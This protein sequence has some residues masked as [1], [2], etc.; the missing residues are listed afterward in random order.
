MPENSSPTELEGQILKVK[1][2]D[3][4]TG[5]AVLSMEIDG[6]RNTVTAVG[7]IVSPTP[8]ERLS[9]RGEWTKH[10]K[11]GAQFKVETFAVKNPVSAKGIENFLGSGL[12]KGI[13]PKMAS[14]IV[15][16]FGT[17]SL[18]IIE[19][20]PE[21]LNKIEGVGPKRIKMIKEAWDEQKHIRDLMIFLQA[22]GVG[23]GTAVRIF[24]KY[25]Q[26]SISVLKKNPYALASEVFGIGFRTA[27]D[28]AEKLGFE[29]NSPVRIKAGI[30]FVL[31]RLSDEGHTYYPE[32]MLNQKS[33]EILGVPADLIENSLKKL[34]MTGEVIIDETFSDIDDT[35]SAVYLKRFHN[36]EKNIA[37]HL[38]RIFS[39]R[40]ALGEINTEKAGKWVQSKSNIELAQRQISAVETAVKSKL[41][42]ITG[43][44]GTGKTT[45]INAIIKIFNELNAKIL[46][47]APTGRAANRMSEAAS[48]PAK[49]IHRALEYAPNQG[50]F[51]RNREN[52][53][54]I[55]VLILDEASMIDT[56][57]M[58]C[59]LEA[60]PDRAAV[61]M[62]GDIC[63]LPSVGAGNVLGDIIASG[64]IPC[65]ELNEIFRQAE[66][67]CIILNAHR[68]NKGLLPE[69][70]NGNKD[71]DFFF[72]EQDNPERVLNIIIE[73]VTKRIPGKFG[74]D[75]LMDIQVIS[76]MHKGTT[77][78]ASL[79][80]ALQEAVNPGESKLVKGYRSFR[81]NDK[82]M[83]TKNNYDKDVYNGDTGKITYIDPNSQTVKILFDQK[84]VTY[85]YSEMDEL[86]L[87]YAISVHKSQ[88]S[89]YPA[90]ILPLLTEHY[91]LLQRNLIY[92]AITRGKKLVVV[93][94]SKKAL[95]MGVKND[96][97]I[98]RYTHLSERIKK[99]SFAF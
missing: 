84:E 72:I 38:K 88:G 83:Q 67:S 76:P 93:T 35:S 73:L 61:I 97:I 46:L 87:A 7:N 86:T 44:P 49:T 85:E 48:S 54:D 80:N 28:I 37:E 60:V 8:G 11:F 74:F 52:P 26:G 69:F 90:V 96:R 98:K 47:A 92:T 55:D 65:I 18:E 36:A 20:S 71:T 68:V 58:S 63:Q 13:G 31:N 94:G 32:K 9:I 57:L 30:V 56:R 25:G 19:N 4:E 10:P 75:P 15:E 42:V 12:I 41:M 16:Q 79:N 62:V 95:T 70:D 29:K 22:Y 81:I 45:V 21:E 3:S 53:L 40:S 50:Q 77:G 6:E 1:Y 5:Y 78:T 99:A 39:S 24:K 14:R 59:L 23:T 34:T 64:K 91:I 51:R 33:R 43:G 2:S 27:D 89:E 17:A 82:V 66:G